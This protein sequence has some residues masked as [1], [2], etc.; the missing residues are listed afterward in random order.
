MNTSPRS[1]AQTP[2]NVSA[3]FLLIHSSHR[4]L[5]R[6]HTGGHEYRDVERPSELEIQGSPWADRHL[7]TRRCVSHRGPPSGADGGADRCTFTAVDAGADAGT[8]CGATEDLLPGFFPLRRSFDLIGPNGVHLAAP[9][10]RSVNSRVSTSAAS[11]PRPAW[12]ATR[13]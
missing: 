2:S 9:L 11:N 13:P 7:I 12:L 10:E 4:R 5:L 6:L 8:D 3:K 1:R